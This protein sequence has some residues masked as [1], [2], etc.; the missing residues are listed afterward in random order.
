MAWYSPSFGS[1]VHEAE[2]LGCVLPFSASLG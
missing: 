2:D 1:L